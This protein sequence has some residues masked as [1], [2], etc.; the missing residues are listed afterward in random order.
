[1][2]EVEYNEIIDS[3]NGTIVDTLDPKIWANNLQ[4]MLQDNH[5][6]KQISKYNM[7]YA[8]KILT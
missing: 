8:R 1:M 6:A 3:R 4:T 7:Q 5:I 2:V